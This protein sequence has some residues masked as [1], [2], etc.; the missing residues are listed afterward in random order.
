MRVDDLSIYSDFSTTGITNITGITET[1]S[2]ASTHYELPTAKSVYD[3]VSSSD[4]LSEILSNGNETTGNNIVITNG[5][6]IVSPSTEAYIEVK[7]GPGVPFAVAPSLYFYTGS[8]VYSSIL[9][10]NKYSVEITSNRDG[11]YAML[12]LEDTFNVKGNSDYYAKLSTNSLSTDRDI[13]IQDLDGTL[14]LTSDITPVGNLY[15]IQFN[16][17]SSF[18]SASEFTYNPTT[19]NLLCSTLSTIHDGTYTVVLAGGG[20][21]VTGTS[22]FFGGA[23]YN[24]VDGDLITILT[25]SGNTIT[26]NSKRNSVIT[27]SLNT[28]SSNDN[29]LI[30]SS[31][32]VVTTDFTTLISSQY[33]DCSVASNSIGLGVSGVTLQ[34]DTTHVNKLVIEDN[35]V[36]SFQ[37]RDVDTDSLYYIYVSGGTLNIAALP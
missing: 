30:N 17:G 3:S 28:I 9:Q 33:C 26:G 14:A 29:V 4:T 37:M 27:S 23:A 24:N 25:S 35:S 19:Y 18:G 16:S 2:S 12:Q 11:T 22:C 15:D 5:D 8:G 31:N 36:Y 1:I 13:I 21:E 32:N 7:G 34:K 10:M 6:V 20:N